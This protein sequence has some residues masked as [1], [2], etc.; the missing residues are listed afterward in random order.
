RAASQPVTAAAIA[1]ELE[2]SVRTVYRD[3]GTLQARRIPVEGAAGVGYVLRRGYELPPL[4][5]TEDEADAIAVGASLLARTGGL[6][7]AAKSVLSK[8][9][10]VVPD[11]LRDYLTTAP[12]YVSKSGA[13]VPA[14]PDLPSTIRD[15]VRAMRKLRKRREIERV[16]QIAASGASVR[17]DC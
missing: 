16:G 10:L 14:Q 6:Q 15:A 1:D 11:P 17:G 9:T 12:V 5:F 8:V 4:M 7:K 3:V 2:V 13:P